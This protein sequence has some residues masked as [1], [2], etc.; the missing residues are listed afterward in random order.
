[1]KLTLRQINRIK[2]LIKTVRATDLAKMFKVSR[3]TI[4]YHTNETLKKYQ[5]D[6]TQTDKYKDYQSKYYK[7]NRKV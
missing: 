1:M 7:L 5:K 4:N 3:H 2:K 6:Y